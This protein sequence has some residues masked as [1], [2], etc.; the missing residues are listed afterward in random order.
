MSINAYIFARGASKGCP[1]KN[2]RQLVDRPLFAHSIRAAKSAGIFA[3]IYV[4][5]DD[6]EIANAAKAW[7][8]EL[9]IRPH[10]LA[11][12]EP[13]SELRAWKHAI[14]NS[15]AC[16]T[17][18]SVPATCPLREPADIVETVKAL[19]GSPRH[20]AAVTVTEAQENPYFVGCTLGRHRLRKLHAIRPGHRQQAPRV[21]NVVGVCYALRSPLVDGVT[22]LWDLNI[23]PVVIPQERALD[24]DTPHDFRLAELLLKDS[25][26]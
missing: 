5:T 17:F 18:V 13:G 2:K 15:E 23:K 6:Q 12:G 16:D 10:A 26:W 8:A 25:P 21:F 20:G 11:Q 9:I 3:H 1:S 24:I 7:G 22:S 4:S 19:Q 14:D